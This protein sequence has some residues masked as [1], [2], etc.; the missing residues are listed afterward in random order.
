MIA[1]RKP[2]IAMAALIAAGLV[3]AADMAQSRTTEATPAATVAARFPAPAETMT[4]RAAQA[5][6]EAA[7]IA[8]PAPAERIAA[9]ACTHEHW[10]YVAD[11]CLVSAAGAKL[12]RP[13]RVIRIERPVTR[14]AAN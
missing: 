11:E 12:N 1:T 6:Q 14:V 7:P 3:A 10:P 2:L 8:D 9:P 4:L 13:S 5:A